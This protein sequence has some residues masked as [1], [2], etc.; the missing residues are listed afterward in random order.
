MLGRRG[1]HDPYQAPSLTGR[2]LD[3]GIA[4]A[5][6]YALVC[7]DRFE[8]EIEALSD[9]IPEEVMPTTAQIREL[10]L[11][12]T[13]TPEDILEEAR[14]IAL[15]AGLSPDALDLEV[16]FLKAIATWITVLEYLPDGGER[17]VWQDLMSYVMARY[18]DIEEWEDT[19]Q[20][21]AKWRRYSNL[22]SQNPSPQ[23]LGFTFSVEAF[24]FQEGPEPN[25]LQL[26]QVISAG[27]LILMQSMVSAG[28]VLAAGNGIP[29]VPL[30]RTRRRLG[31][32]Q[33]YEPDRGVGVV[34]TEYGHPCRLERSQLGGVDTYLEEGTAL[35]FEV[36]SNPRLGVQVA[37]RVAVA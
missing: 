14:K 10:S 27:V 31:T 11:L 7:W 8:D 29:S 35:S 23:C 20:V 34:L 4:A 24:S 36:W 9:T 16:G 5:S 19:E 13:L 1:K 33:L 30:A 22:Y 28:Q 25:N 37:R 12:A 6:E 15:T 21:I 2:D 32:V 26:N 3:P 18:D 17:E